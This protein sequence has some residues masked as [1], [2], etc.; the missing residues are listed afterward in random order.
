M[1]GS[2]SASSSPRAISISMSAPP[3][4]T[5]ARTARSS[6]GS[7][8]D[9]S[10]LACSH[11]DRRRA[12]AAAPR[13]LV[14]STRTPPAPRRP[15]LPPPTPPARRRCRGRRGSCRRR[16]R[17]R[18]GDRR[19]SPAATRPASR[20]PGRTPAS[21]RSAV[22]VGAPAGGERA[23][24]RLLDQHDLLEAR[25]GVPAARRGVALRQLEQRRRRDHRRARPK[26]S[27]SRT[28]ASSDVDHRGRQ[29]LGQQLERP[30]PRTAAAP[31]VP[32]SRFHSPRVFAGSPSRPGT[33]RRPTVRAAPRVDADHRRRQG[34]AAGV[35]DDRDGVAVEQRDRRVAWCRGRFR[36]GVPSPW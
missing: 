6:R 22:L 25:P 13:G 5:P 1:N 36:R 9:S 3:T 12:S 26:P 29:L 19:A 33:A 15:A 7:A 30:R 17:R 11:G 21:S 23:G 16:D 20:R 27:T 18:A 10:I 32:I 4:S 14:R 31:P 35:G 34:F 24:D 8:R 2:T 28:S